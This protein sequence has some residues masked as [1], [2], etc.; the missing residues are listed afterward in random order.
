GN[1]GQN[2]TLRWVG[3]PLP[4]PGT[5]VGQPTNPVPANL[6]DSWEWERVRRYPKLN[7]A[8]NT[9]RF[10]YIRDN[11][12]VGYGNAPMCRVT[13]TPITAVAGVAQVLGQASMSVSITVDKCNDAAC[14]SVTTKG[15]KTIVFNKANEMVY[16]EPGEGVSKTPEGG[17]F[18]GQNA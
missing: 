15:T 18:Y 8:N 12:G 13:F 5:I 4:A 6:S 9:T 2:N 11:T 16:W 3:C 1:T 10:Y 7:D 14:S 17:A